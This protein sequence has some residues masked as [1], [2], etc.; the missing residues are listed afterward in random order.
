MATYTAVTVAVVASFFI[1][2]GVAGWKNIGLFYSVLVGLL[3]GLCV[4]LVGQYYTSGRRGPVKDMAE[5]AETAPR[6]TFTRG[7]SDGMMST[8]VPIVA[9][10]IAL[11]IAFWTASRA[12]PGGGIFGIGLAALGMLTGAGMLVAINSFRPVLAAG[13]AVAEK[14]GVEGEGL[15]ATAD[16]VNE[17]GPTAAAGRAYTVAAAGL[18][19]ISLF[20]AFVYS[21]GAGTAGLLGDYKFFASLL[22]GAMLAFVFTALALDGAGRIVL[23]MAPEPDAKQSDEAELGGITPSDG[24]PVAAEAGDEAAK[25]SGAELSDEGEPEESPPSEKSRTRTPAAAAA[26]AAMYET[27]IPAVLVIAVPI[28][29]GRF[30]G[31][32]ALTGMLAGAVAAGFLLACS[33]PTHQECGARRA[34]SSPTANPGYR[35]CC[36]TTSPETP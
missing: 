5:S 36:S 22:A 6:F 34:A 23:A 31:K 25:Q 28:L 30:A 29:V 27:L 9:I 7:V 26:R 24:S 20:A 19:A 8:L 4:G 1:V 21:S 16:L 33:Y 10:V 15:D 3:A 13:N 18:A 32:Q 2:W 12:V 17:A 11:G 35:I 14:A